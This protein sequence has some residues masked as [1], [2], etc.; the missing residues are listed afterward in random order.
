MS[1][2]KNTLLLIPLLIFFAVFFG[3]AIKGTFY[4][5]SEADQKFAQILKAEFHYDAVVK[6]VGK[7]TWI[8]LSRDRRIFT[9]RVSEGG[10]KEGKEKASLQYL[11]GRFEDQSFLLEYDVM[12]SFKSLK[13]SG[14][15]S[16]YTEA[17]NEEYRNVL[18]AITRIYFNAQDPPTFIV[19]IFADI[20]DGIEV[21]DTF[22]VEDFR[23][24]QSS[25]LPYEEYQL[26]VLT[27]SRGDKRIIGDTTGSHLD[28]HDIN[29]QD[30]LIRQIVKRI[31]FKYAQSDFKPSEETEKEFL[32]I[33][34]RALD[35]Y[36]FTDF[37]S[38]KLHD[39]RNDTIRTIEREELLKLAQ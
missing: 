2:R 35:S 15:A 3:C 18:G 25:A 1:F 7:T 10:Q 28:M 13:N 31:N 32:S 30:F 9:L 39:L 38:L 34:A 20:K 16:A 17:F 21:T 11:D 36:H 19:T 14:L 8:Y 12:L 24:Y 29:W 5:P 33:A 37:T 22:S 4:S 6:T 26:R 27:D 23:K